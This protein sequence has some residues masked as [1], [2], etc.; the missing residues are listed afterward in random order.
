MSAFEIEERVFRHIVAEGT[1]YEVGSQLAQAIEDDPGLVARYSSGEPELAGQGF[2]GLKGVMSL[3]DQYCP[4][5]NEGICG[6]ADA[7]GI[8]PGKVPFYQA[9]TIAPSKPSH[10]GCSHIAV[11]PSATEIG[12]TLVARTHE[13]SLDWQDL[14]LIVAR[15]TGVPSHL[16]YSDLLFGR[17]DGMNEY[18]LCV[19]T[20]SGGDNRAP[21]SMGLSEIFIVRAIL[22]RCRSVDEALAILQ[23]LTPAGSINVSVADAEGRAALYEA[24]GGTHAARQ[25]AAG[26]STEPYLFSTNHTSLP[27]MTEYNE[28]SNP[29]M[30]ANSR[31]R[32]CLISSRLGA[33]RPKITR[34][35]LR[36]MLSTHIPDGLCAH[37]YSRGFGTVFQM[38]YDASSLNADVCFGAPTHSQWRSVSLADPV[39]LVRVVSVFPNKR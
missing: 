27:G 9:M 28:N 38:I 19:T 29:S 7:A 39:G 14:C 5:L 22:D 31:A 34:E 4:S 2:G 24:N 13:F 17:S 10:R 6:F 25:V 8:H 20:S 37:F 36:G 35:T 26:D 12:H 15:K 33:V 11:L 30:L 23:E 1:P 21:A 32:M 18:G 3:C 16:G